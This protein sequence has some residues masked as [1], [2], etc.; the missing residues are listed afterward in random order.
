MAIQITVPIWIHIATLV[1][2]AL[3]EICSPSASSCCYYCC[4]NYVAVSWIS[5]L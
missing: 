2:R 3:V 1:K 5:Y 4:I